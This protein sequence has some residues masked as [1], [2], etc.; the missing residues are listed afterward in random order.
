V[1]TNYRIEAVR[2][3]QAEG[4]PADLYLRLVGAES[5]WNPRARS[6]VGALGFA[7]LMPGTARGLGVNPLDPIQNLRGG[8]RYLAQQYRRFG[9]WDKALAA[10][11]AGPGAVAKYGGVPPFKETQAYVR[12]ILAGW[13]PGSA[14]PAAASG[15][16][17]AA[18]AADQSRAL[19]Q[20]AAIAA[21]DPSALGSRQRRFLTDPVVRGQQVGGSP[22][23][24][25]VRRIAH[26]QPDLRSEQPAT[27]AADAGHVTYDN[28]NMQLLANDGSYK[29]AEELAKRFGLALASTYRSPAKNRAVGGSK[30]S[31]HMRRGAATDFAGSPAAMRK[32]AEWAIRSGRFREVFYDPVGQ[33]DNGRFSRRGIGGHSDHVHITL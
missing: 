4:I 12:K 31:A 9:S 2:A 32:L 18:P 29:W 19:A 27:V 20:I 6:P 11:N 10:Y 8:A 17:V 3:A 23:G 5:G 30:T 33:W 14:Q 22:L 1:A 24:E 25:F 15:G 28:P 16:G 21:Q 26:I 7:Q 13:T